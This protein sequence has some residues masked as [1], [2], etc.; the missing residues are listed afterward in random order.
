MH[1]QQEE[2]GNTNQVGDLFF[3]VKIQC[4]PKLGQCPYCCW[5]Q[6]QRTGTFQSGAI[7]VANI[8]EERGTGGQFGVWYKLWYKL[9]CGINQAEC[10]S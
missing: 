4:M 7:L 8:A 5:E 6:M 3:S 10:G 9:G 1:L 2:R